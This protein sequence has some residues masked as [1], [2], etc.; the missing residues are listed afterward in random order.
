MSMRDLMK[1]L[2]K[3]R[4]VLKL[5]EPVAYGEENDGEDEVGS[6]D[7]PEDK[8]LEGVVEGDKDV[9]EEGK[10]DDDNDEIMPPAKAADA[11]PSRLDES[12]ED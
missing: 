11:G 3:R 12:A 6:A 8:E 7:V 2:K 1:K 4:V 5:S 9:A 10:E